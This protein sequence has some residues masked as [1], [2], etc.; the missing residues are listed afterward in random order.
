MDGIVT[1]RHVE[2]GT[3]VAAG[4]PVLTL[5][6]ERGREAVIDVPAEF[7]ALMAPGTAF[8]AREHGD[9]DAPEVSA[10]LRL[11]EPVANTR[12]RGRRLR[13]TLD[14]SGETMR[15]GSLITARLAGG[16]TP[17]ITLPTTALFGPE[18]AMQVW[19]VDP[20]TRH[21]GA[22][23]V[24]PGRPVGE[25]IEIVAGLSPGDEI[26]VK[27]VHSLNEGDLV[28]EREE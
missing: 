21:V 24:T 17:V 18:G 27:G 13:L 11:I 26:V 6:S 4:T 5:A 8:T 7:V 3:V 9:G 15:I 1:A 12:L 28:G 25:R 23:A 19:R 2:E 20:A 10:R 22:V 16:E 14:G